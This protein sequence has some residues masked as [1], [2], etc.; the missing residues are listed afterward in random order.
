M[1]KLTLWAPRGRKARA[2]LQMSNDVN[3]RLRSF[4]DGNVPALWQELSIA[5]PPSATKART[6]TSAYR[7]DDD[8]LPEIVVA[9]VRGL[10]EE[11]AFA[12]AA[13]HLVSRGLL[14]ADD[15]AVLAKLRDL[16]PAGNPVHLGGDHQLPVDNGFRASGDAAD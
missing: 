13:K 6:R 10:V 16:H 8:T 9:G 14:S 4:A 11:G 5:Y 15:P 2:P 3:R 12:K 1:P 7:G